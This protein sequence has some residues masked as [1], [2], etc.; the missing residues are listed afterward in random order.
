[1]SGGV[2]KIAAVGDIMLGDHPVC[3]GHGVRTQADRQGLSTMLAEVAPELRRHDFVIGNLECV[4]SDVGALPRDLPSQELRG[5]PAFARD[6]A[7]AGFNVVSIANNHILQHGEAAFDD[8]LEVLRAAGIAVAGV[9]APD[10]SAQWQPLGPAQSPLAFL[11]FSLRPEQYKKSNDRYAQPSVDTM[12]RQVEAC[13]REGAQVVVSLHWGDEYLPLPA[14]R[15]REL[16]HALVDKG[17][18]LILGHHPHVLQ[19]VEE[20]RNA[21]IAYSLGNFMFDSWI[22]Q[23]CKSML[24]S[25]DLSPDGVQRWEL[26]PVRIAS[27]WR[28]RLLAGAEKDRSLREM[29]ELGRRWA[30]A[31]SAPAVTD[32]QYRQMA[33]RAESVYRRDSYG[34]FLRNIWRYSPWVIRASLARALARRVSG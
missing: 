21:L 10:H 18:S 27:D 29:E 28:P 16:A 1:M 12:L 26:V 23:C 17:A 3:F 14:P 2:V 22:D 4:L 11:G 30:A 25:V 7:A 32:E 19:P 8:N 31:E 13:R 34:Y 24:L 20:Y 15:Q 33:R 6:L 5:R 9:A